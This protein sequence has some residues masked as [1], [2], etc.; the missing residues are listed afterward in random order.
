ME[1][2]PPFFKINVNL[3]GDVRLSFSDVV[4]LGILNHY[5]FYNN[6]CCALTTNEILEQLKLSVDRK[7]LFR[8]FDTLEKH[9]FIYRVVNP[10]IKGGK[11]RKIYMTYNDITDTVYNSVKGVIKQVPVPRSKPPE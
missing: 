4:V 1:N 11:V 3:L 7:T 5:C 6:G 8:A 2:W 10:S 9:G